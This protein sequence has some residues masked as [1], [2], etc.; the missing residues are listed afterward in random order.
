MMISYI[1]LYSL[2]IAIKSGIKAIES[3]IKAINSL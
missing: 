1:I 3:G 2:H